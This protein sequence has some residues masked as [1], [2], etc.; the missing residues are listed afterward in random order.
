MSGHHGLRTSVF[1]MT[2]LGSR[3]GR[4]MPTHPHLPSRQPREKFR[5]LAG[6]GVLPVSQAKGLACA[7]VLGGALHRP[8]V[9]G[10]GAQEMETWLEA[11][12][13]PL[14]GEPRSFPQHQRAVS[15]PQACL[16]RPG[17]HTAPRPMDLQR[18]S[19]PFGTTGRASKRSGTDAGQQGRESPL[20][21]QLACSEG[22]REGTQ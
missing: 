9:H 22:G 7:E 5:S 12:L 10:R 19:S 4:G 21:A 18:R 14:G 17:Q 3:W 6:L 1:S 16:F 11:W 2:A 13:W 8:E 15:R 20:N